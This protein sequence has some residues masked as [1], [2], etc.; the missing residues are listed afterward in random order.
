MIKNDVIYKLVYKEIPDD[1]GGRLEKLI[2]SEPIPARVSYFDNTKSILSSTDTGVRL[3]DYLEVVTDEPLSSS[4]KYRY[5]EQTYT[6]RR[7]VVRRR[8][9]FSILGRIM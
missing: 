2:S 8:E 6:V 3:E 4:E 9:T 1:E 7:S 5:K